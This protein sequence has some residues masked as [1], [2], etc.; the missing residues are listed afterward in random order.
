MA[1]QQLPQD[2]AEA[3]RAARLDSYREQFLGELVSTWEAAATA[4]RVTG[5]PLPEFDREILV[6]HGIADLVLPEERGFEVVEPAPELERPIVDQM[7][8]VERAAAD[9]TPELETDE[10]QTE[11]EVLELAS[12]DH[13]AGAL[14][15]RDEVDVD[16]EPVRDDL[17]EPAAVLE[18]SPQAPPV[19]EPEP[20]P[21]LD[22]V[23]EPAV[24][25]ETLGPEWAYDVWA[26]PTEKPEP[27]VEPAESE[28]AVEAKVDDD[29]EARRE[30]ETERQVEADREREAEQDLAEQQA[31][32]ERQAEQER[33]AEAEREHQAEL[34][35]E[36]ELDAADEA[37]H[38]EQEASYQR[39]LEETERDLA[40]ER[41]EVERDDPEM[42][43][44]DPSMDM[45]LY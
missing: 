34:E 4:H 25:P 38:A 28:L 2:L 30:P 12:R 13:E 20:E 6:R 41:D 21:Q 31:E 33:A 5:S 37:W 32:S 11:P 43:R 26:Q 27:V 40:L 39:G 24:E 7:L 18:P 44:D 19:A 17:E 8:D 29:L 36:A 22:E 45:E 42:D 9:A 16:V 35:R 14:L 1:V 3:D 15:A 23:P 10:A